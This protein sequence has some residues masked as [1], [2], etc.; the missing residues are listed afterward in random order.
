MK[1]LIGGFDLNVNQLL[2]NDSSSISSNLE[3]RYLVTDI[4]K[5]M[6]VWL[7]SAITRFRKKKHESY[8]MFPILSLVTSFN[9]QNHGN[10]SPSLTKN[11]HKNTGAPFLSESNK[12]ILFRQFSPLRGEDPCIS[13]YT[14]HVLT[15]EKNRSGNSPK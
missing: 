12:I 9:K 7:L 10:M 11:K 15:Q 5:I 13:V 2:K 6:W 8:Q 14:N 4:V 1:F 3:S